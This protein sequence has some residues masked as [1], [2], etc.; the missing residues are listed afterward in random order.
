MSKNPKDGFDLGQFLPY[1]LN[2]AAET[3][4]HA[5]QP[6]YAEKYG[7][8]RTQWRVIANL[9]KFGAMTAKHICDVSHLEKTKVSRAIM[10]LE[11]EGLLKRQTSSEDRRAE[12]LT[13]TAKGAKRFENLGEEAVAFDAEL[14]KKLGKEEAKQLAALLQKLISS[15]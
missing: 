6:V 10:A 2:Q 3:T 11:D 14:R 9:G 13:L 12:V 4:S 7:M 8:S 5:F 15:N 1:I